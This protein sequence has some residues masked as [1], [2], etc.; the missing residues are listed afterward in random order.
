M[1]QLNE[2]HRVYY[3]GPGPLREI[4]QDLLDTFGSDENATAFE[5]VTFERYYEEGQLETEW[6]A[7]VVTYGRAVL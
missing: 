7:T 2:N 3:T 6:T 1:R 5:S 4:F